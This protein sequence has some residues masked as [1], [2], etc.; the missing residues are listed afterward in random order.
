MFNLEFWVAWKFRH[1]AGNLVEAA[2]PA[3]V[4]IPWGFVITFCALYYLHLRTKGDATTLTT[5]GHQITY[6]G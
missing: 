4:V 1:G 6:Q 3:Y 5:G 2:H